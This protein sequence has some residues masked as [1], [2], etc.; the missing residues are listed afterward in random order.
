MS[1]KRPWVTV[2]KADSG[3][4]AQALEA[5]TATAS[6]KAFATGAAREGGRIASRILKA[7]RWTV[8]RF[9]KSVLFADFTVFDLVCCCCG[10]ES[11]LLVIRKVRP[12]A[13]FAVGFWYTMSYVPIHSSC[14]AQSILWAKFLTTDHGIGP[15]A[16]SKKSSRLPC[17]TQELDNRAC[18]DHCSLSCASIAEWNPWSTKDARRVGRMS[19]STWAFHGHV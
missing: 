5:S 8:L 7:V 11:L 2:N 15:P 4:D 1:W 6:K 12:I 10:S 17:L 19:S 14:I 18:N 16:H 9:F 13:R 3:R